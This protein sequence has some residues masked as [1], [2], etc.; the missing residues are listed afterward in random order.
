MAV[1]SVQKPTRDGHVLTA[2]AATTAASATNSIGSGGNGVVTTTVTATGS[3]GNSYTMHVVAGVGNDVAL[4]AALSGTAITVTLGTDSGG[5]LDASKNTA[6]LVAAAIDALANVTA[7]ASGSGATAISAV[8]GPTA[9]TGGVDPRDAFTNTG[10]E[11]VH[12][13]NG[14]VSA[15]RTVTFDAPGT[16]SFGVSAHP[17]HDLVVT[18]AAGE[19]R[20]IGP[21]PA[22][23]F[24]D[25]NGRVQVTYS[26]PADLTMAVIAAS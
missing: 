19:T 17:N 7:V 10:G 21:F 25:S 5:A 12:I 13:T 8:S 2:A 9:F 15:S 26:T 6:T 16:C 11:F 1:H 22:G 18:I 20:L 24:N 4:S 3:A 14:H 23:R